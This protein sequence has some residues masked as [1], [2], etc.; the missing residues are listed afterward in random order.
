MEQSERDS[1]GIGIIVDKGKK[2]ESTMRENPNRPN[3]EFVNLDE[4]KRFI[5]N[6]F[7]IFKRNRKVQVKSN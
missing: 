6:M 3:I 2:A 5:E 4:H 7:S 1:I